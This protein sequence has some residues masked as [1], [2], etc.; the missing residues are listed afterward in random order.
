MS[1]S[2]VYDVALK[3]P[4]QAAP[5]LSRTLGCQVLLKRED[6]QPVH[7]FKIRGAYQKIA[8]LSEMERQKGVIAASA[9][10][11]AQ[12]VA[13]SAQKLG[14]NALIVMP[15]TTPSIKVEA[16]KGFGAEVE[17]VGDNYSEAYEHCLHRIDETGMTFIHPFD[18][19]E[20]IAGQGTVA[21]EILEQNPEVT[22]IFV[23]IGGGGLIAGIA[24]AV[25]NQKPD[26]QIIGVE[27][28]DSCAMHDSVQAGHPVALPHVGIFADGV[29]VKK[30][31]EHTFQKV[32]EY[33][34]RCMTV[35]TDQICAAIKSI[36]E[37]TRSIVEPAGALAVAGIAAS[38]LPSDAVAVAICSGANMTFERLQF[39][40]ER[41]LLGSGKEALFTVTLKE[42]PNALKEFCEKVV[43]DHNIT[44]FNYRLHKRSEAHIF[45]GVGFSGPEDKQ[46]FTNT[47]SQNGYDFIDLSDDQIAK[48]HIRH[49][50]GGISNSTSNERLYT[51]GFPERPGALHDF[52]QIVGSS[53]VNISLFHYR[54]QGG[55]VGRV[56]IGFETAR[57]DQQFIQG[58]D[59]SNYDVEPAE[60]AAIEIFL[61]EHT[62]SRV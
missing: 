32:V 3:T 41:T 12:G 58:L 46:K 50:V 11:H 57:G 37:D 55:D 60:S 59:D 13:L 6:L 16:V 48:E 42:E 40:A 45:V 35:T 23:P 2:S 52:L 56:L 39:I 5:K 8:G 14:M 24:E 9:G 36:F 31:G 51:V 17:L 53:D 10:N 15:R 30:V 33:V 20:V 1:K 18:D 62:A 44:E 27:P 47:M 4:L 29:A 7:S 38:S 34:D 22:H 49:M 21:L 28:T 26:V 19:L 61:R 43:R 54:G 25:K